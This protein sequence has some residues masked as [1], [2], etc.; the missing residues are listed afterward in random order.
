MSWPTASAA[1]WAAVILLVTLLV[2]YQLTRGI[3]S[4][5]QPGQAPGSKF[6]VVQVDGSGQQLGMQLRRDGVDIIFVHGLGSNPDST[7][8]ARRSCDAGEQHRSEDVTDDLV[9]WVMDLLIDDLPPTVRRKTRIFFYNHD[10]YWQCG[11]VQTRLW[12]LAGN[13]LHH[14]RGRIHHS[15]EEN[16]RGLVF[17]AYSYGG[18]L[19]KQAGKTKPPFLT[20]YH[21][22]TPV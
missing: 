14:L 15:E 10:S 9:C 3:P 18:L 11:A 1:G 6:G 2:Y 20:F 7:W 4:R 19:V 17:V 8:Q 16:A 13:M 21:V 22:V 5:Q 12:N